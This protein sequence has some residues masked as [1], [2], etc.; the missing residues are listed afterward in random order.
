MAVLKEKRQMLETAYAEDEATL[1]RIKRSREL[2]EA[3]SP[4]M[5]EWNEGTI[6]QLVEMVKVISKD[7]LLV[8]LKDGTE[9][10]QSMMQ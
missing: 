7:Q 2:L 5:E 10:H 4:Y 6:R 9:I 1:R 8:V 3:S